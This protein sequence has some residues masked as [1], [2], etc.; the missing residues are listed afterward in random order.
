MGLRP[1]YV[2]HSPTTIVLAFS[3]P[4][5]AARAEDTANYRLVAAGRDHR[6]IA[7]RRARYDA[8]SRSVSLR[9]AGPLPAG[10]TYWLTVAGTPGALTSA[11]GL[12]LDGAGTGQPGNDYL[13]HFGRKVLPNPARIELLGNGDFGAPKVLPPSKARTVRHGKS[14]L[15]PWQITAGSVNVQSYW[16]AAWGTYSLDLNGTSAGTIQQT[17]ATTSGQTYQ[18]S[19]YYANNPD[20]SARTDTASVSLTGAGTLLEWKLSHAGSLPSAMNYTRFLGT[21][22]ADSTTTTLRF[23]ATTRGAYGIILDAVSLT[24]VNMTQGG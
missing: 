13:V 23:A 7:I 1:V 14:S 4:M 24:A 10:R 3:E 19:F 6:V 9:L 20:R 12:P 5:T 22:V 16:P 15:A 8:A 18:V 2:R 11:T 21:F 17:F